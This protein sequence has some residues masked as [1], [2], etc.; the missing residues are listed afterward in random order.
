M[1]ETQVENGRMG[2]LLVDFTSNV[3]HGLVV[4]L[5]PC[6]PFDWEYWDNKTDYRFLGF[7]IIPWLFVSF[8]LWFPTLLSALLL[9]FIWRKTPAER[10]SRGF[11]V[12]PTAKANKPAV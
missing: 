5:R 1:A 12:A 3:D 10:N 11:P 6:R 8:P 9:W 4:L 2:L 7:S